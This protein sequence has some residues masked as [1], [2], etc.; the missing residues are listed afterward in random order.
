MVGVNGIWITDQQNLVLDSLVRSHNAERLRGAGAVP[1]ECP[2]CYEF[3]F[4]SKLRHHLMYECQTIEPEARAV[5][6]R[7]EV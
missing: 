4:G 3:L 6:F 7:Q 5:L 2:W 1:Q